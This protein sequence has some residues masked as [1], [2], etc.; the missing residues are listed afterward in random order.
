MK[1]KLVILTG[2]GI[3]AESGIKTFRDSGGLWEGHNVEDVA[4]PQGWH[5]NPTLVL[6]FYNKRRQELKTVKPNE[7]H[8]ILAD[9]END[10]D[11]QII[12]Q[13]V[14]NL[15]ERAGSKNV[16]HLHGELLKVRST[17][18]ENYILDWSENLH[19]GDFD[20]KKNQL[21]PHIVWF[22]E[23]VPALEY[24]V[25]LVQLADILIIIGTSL[26]VYPAASLM[27]F[28]PEDCLVYYIDPNPANVS[29][30]P[31]NFKIIEALASKGMQILQ[32]ELKKQQ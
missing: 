11:I 16:L 32:K 4:T 12:T 13:N 17:K 6:D 27:H 31:Q 1:K 24:A 29:N 7:A 19:L 5:K 21:R 23:D 26:Q 9:L 8:L 18:N 3:S 20:D 14:D 22:G 25:E 2:A 30:T 28:A 15:H 10:F